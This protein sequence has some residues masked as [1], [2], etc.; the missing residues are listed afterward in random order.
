MDRVNKTHGIYIIIMRLLD[1]RNSLTLQLDQVKT[2]IISAPNHLGPIS[3][4]SQGKQ[5]EISAAMRRNTHTLVQLVLS[6]G[7]G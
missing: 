1:T 6:K 4:E 7:V 2:P 3:G 5:T